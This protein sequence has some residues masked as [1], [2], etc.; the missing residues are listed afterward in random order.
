GNALHLFSF[1]RV[2]IPSFW[3]VKKAY[4][5]L[6]LQYHPDKNQGNEA[7]ADKFKDVT[8]AYEVLSDDKERRTYD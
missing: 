6:A 4:R 1:C 8:A 7:S 5:K 2:S 3:Q